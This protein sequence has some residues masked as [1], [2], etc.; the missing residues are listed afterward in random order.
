MIRLNI[1]FEDIDHHAA[2]HAFDDGE[3]DLYAS[4]K[5]PA[6]LFDIFAI[7]FYVGKINNHKWFNL[8]TQEEKFEYLYSLLSESGH[9]CLK[10]WKKEFVIPMWLTERIWS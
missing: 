1:D 3:G 8:K 9:G 5:T 10:I 6:W 4:L 7:C 2:L